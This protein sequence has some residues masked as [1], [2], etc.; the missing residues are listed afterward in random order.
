VSKIWSPKT[1]CNILCSR[2]KRWQILIAST[3]FWLER[4]MQDLILCQNYEVP[5]QPATSCAGGEKD[6]RSW[7]PRIL[8]DLREEFKT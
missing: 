3:T 4:K 5:R 8:S 1:T 7:L 2:W 6:D